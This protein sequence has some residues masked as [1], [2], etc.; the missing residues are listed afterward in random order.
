[1]NLL[2]GERVLLESPTRTVVLTTHRVRHHAEAI[3]NAEVTS[4][5]LEKIASCRVVRTSHPVLLVLAALCLAV[6]VIVGVGG[7]EEVG[8]IAGVCLALIFV[9]AYFA[10]RHQ[11][12][13]L[14]SDGGAAIVV[15][16]KGMKVQDAVNFIDQTE[17]S[18]NARFLA[19]A[20][21]RV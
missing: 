10:S 17:A 13:A 6:G 14:A 7:R 11:V 21:G 19:P 8:L 5:M 18:K 1:V 20:G 9:I 2:P 15:P 16:T 12:L 4:I 3:G